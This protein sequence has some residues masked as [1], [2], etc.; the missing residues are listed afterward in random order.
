MLQRLYAHNYRCLV[1]FDLS[2]NGLSS[3]L[4]VGRNGVG[5]S[6]I[7]NVLR[8]LQQIARGQNRV[9]ELVGVADF[10]FGGLELPMRFEIEVALKQR[11]YK[12]EL[13]LELPQDFR[14]LRVLEEKLSVDEETVYSREKAQVVQPR[15]KK[16]F[17]EFSVDWHLI[18]LPVIQERSEQDPLHVFKHWLARMII[19]A[20]IPSNITG[21]SNGE[22]LEP[23]ED[24]TNFGEW[25]S[26]LLARY[27][28]AYKEVDK[29][30]QEVIPDL[31]DVQNELVAKESKSMIVRFEKDSSILTLDFDQLSDG[32]K[33]FFVCATVLAANKYYGPVFCFWDEPDN[34]LSL[35]E[36]GH[37]IVSLRRSFN[38][39]GFLLVAS[40]NEEAIRRFSPENTFVLDRKSHLEPTIKRLLEETQ[41]RGDVIGRMIVG[42]VVL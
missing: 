21:I 14:E 31:S 11:L 13:A 1:N 24:G 2:L 40:H 35:S 20:P 39:Q 17:A 37:M 22:T 19:L 27:P 9:K 29:Y 38:G 41:Y 26:G 30:L 42:D 6:T 28:A 36:V 16:E 23:E 32:E 5:K 33:C 7:K 34:Y 12:Y 15:D 25:F 4:L 10:A 18:A 8:V 3:V